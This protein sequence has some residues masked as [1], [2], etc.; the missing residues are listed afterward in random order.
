M[1]VSKNAAPVYGSNIF[2]KFNFDK[3]NLTFSMFNGILSSLNLYE[4]N[5]TYIKK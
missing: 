4:W 2:K 5:G 1:L 3:L